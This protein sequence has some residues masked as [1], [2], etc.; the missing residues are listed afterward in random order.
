MF[1]ANIGTSITFGASAEDVLRI[2]D[3]SYTVSANVQTRSK[4]TY[5]VGDVTKTIS[6]VHTSEPHLKVPFAD[7]AERTAFIEGFEEQKGFEIV[8]N[9]AV[10]RE[11]A[12][13][14]KSY[15]T[16]LSA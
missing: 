2:D 3:D 16:V 9:G 13:T 12:V 4:D 5:K 11:T 7:D 10:M 1:I 6:R 15:T 8:L 14:A